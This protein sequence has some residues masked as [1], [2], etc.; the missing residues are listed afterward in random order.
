MSPLHQD[1]LREKRIRLLV[2]I[3]MDKHPEL[4]DVPSVFDFAKTD[5]QRQILSFWAVPN[6]MGR[7]FGSPPGTP[8]DRVAVLRRAFE[9]TMKDPQLVA[10]ARK[11][12]LAVDS[13]GG[14]EVTRL[15]DQL[16]AMPKG[17]IAKAARASRP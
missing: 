16:Y 13:I 10:E 8:P 3:A 15:V 14:D 12:K 4:S 5:E 7:P 2:Q 9:A 1:W 17:L 11:M 6:K